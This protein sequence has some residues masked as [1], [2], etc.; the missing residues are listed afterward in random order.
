MRAAGQTPFCIH[1]DSTQS[2]RTFSLRRGTGRAQH[3]TIKDMTQSFR[4]VSLR[5][6]D[7]NGRDGAGNTQVRLST[8]YYFRRMVNFTLPTSTT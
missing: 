2:F 7:G 6:G 1:E 5:R 3:H 8:H 4:T